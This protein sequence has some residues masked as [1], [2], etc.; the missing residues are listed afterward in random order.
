MKINA[1]SR[2]HS[3]NEHIFL[4][5]GYHNIVKNKAWHSQLAVNPWIICHSDE[6]LPK[7][8]MV[9]GDVHLGHILHKLALFI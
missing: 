4:D 9:V 3:R 5:T 1:H 2:F 6:L 8:K 7:S